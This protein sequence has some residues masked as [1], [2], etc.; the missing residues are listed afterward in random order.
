MSAVTVLEETLPCRATQ[1]LPPSRKEGF[2]HEPCVLIDG[3]D[4]E[5]VGRKRRVLL[6]R[7][8]E[9]GSLSDDDIANLDQPRFVIG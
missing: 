9:A 2:H 1:A 5:D 7:L 6:N 4:R 8:L 3:N